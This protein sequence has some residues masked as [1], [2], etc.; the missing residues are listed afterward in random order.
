MFQPSRLASP[1]IGVVGYLVKRWRS[2]D[3]FGA[4]PRVGR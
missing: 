1:K 2:A 4:L 3:P